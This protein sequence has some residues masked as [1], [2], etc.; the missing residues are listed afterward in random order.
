MITKPALRAVAKLAGQPR[1]TPKCVNPAL[2]DGG[3]GLALAFAQLD[4][5][6]PGEGWRAMAE[7]YLAA[8][9]AGAERLGGTDASPSLYGGLAGIAFA[10]WQLTHDPTVLPEVHE[11]VVRQAVT[12]ARSL[13]EQS[14]ERAFDVVFG[15]TGTAAYL[16]SRRD[17]P[18]TREALTAVLKALISADCG[19]DHG[20]AH[21]GSGPLALLSLAAMG[22]VLVAGQ[23]DA[24]ARWSNRQTGDLPSTSW[25][26][27]R[28]G[29]ARALWLAGTALDDTALRERALRMLK[30]VHRQA[31]APA[32]GLCHG[33]AGLLHIT[34]RFAQDTG[35]PELVA[36]V[37]Q[38]AA[39]LAEAPGGGGPGFLDGAAGV[40]LA[41]LAV[42]CPEPP[43]WDQALLLS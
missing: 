1:P 42:A 26:R 6:Q 40:V 41:L 3:P 8:S 22:G 16:L 38:L 9:A 17:E 34:F 29:I 19:Q 15:L 39:E 13:T 28:A 10:A 32:A 27:G 5:C 20:M 24:I 23:R 4:R 37:D 30:T 12:R 7:G 14:P 25:C 2:A 11:S 21:G 43:A 33:R 35:D 18:A 31:A 36:T